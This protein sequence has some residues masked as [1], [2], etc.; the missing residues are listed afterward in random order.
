MSGAGALDRR[1]T[2]ERAALVDDGYQQIE[3]WGPVATLWASHTAISDGERW[4][5]GAA[6]AVVNARF[7]V[8]YRADITTKDRLIFKGRAF[9]IV[10]V[11]EIGRR[12]FTEITAGLADE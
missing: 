8:R 11:K 6:R 12:E 5:A 9:N 7:V 1:I 3:A 2:I 10:A 4:A